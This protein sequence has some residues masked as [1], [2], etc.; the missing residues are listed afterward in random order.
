MPAP[1]TIVVISAHL[2]ADISHVT[3]GEKPELIYDYYAFSPEAVVF[4]SFDSSMIDL[5]RTNSLALEH[6]KHFLE[7]AEKR[8]VA[9]SEISSADHGVDQ[10]DS[11]FEQAVAQ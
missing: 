7:F 5:S 6:L 1:D 3:T 4:S 9:L 8:P 10:F 11:D 2:E